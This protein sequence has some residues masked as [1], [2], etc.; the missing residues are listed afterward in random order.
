MSFKYRLQCASYSHAVLV[1][2]LDSLGTHSSPRRPH[3]C[4][5]AGATVGGMATTGTMVQPCCAMFREPP[6]HGGGGLRYYSE[7]DSSAASPN[8]A[9]FCKITVWMCS[10]AS[11]GCST[12]SA[13]CRISC[14]CICRSCPCT[15]ASGAI[16][17]RKHQCSTV[18]Q[19]MC[20]TRH[21]THVLRS[22]STSGTQRVG[23]TSTEMDQMNP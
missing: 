9:S 13:V 10:T 22:S 17:G 18:V 12:A 2:R 8:L 21:H 14:A 19:A 6:R 4:R 20:M 3:S 23:V 7:A 16:G 1:C 11:C 15:Q 5:P